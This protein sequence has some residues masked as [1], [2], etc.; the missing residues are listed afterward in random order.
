MRS[1]GG[2]S[3][4]GVGDFSVG[5]F[6]RDMVPSGG[7][8]GRRILSRGGISDVG[9]PASGGSDERGGFSQCAGVGSV[10]GLTTCGG[11]LEANGQSRSGCLDT[12]FMNRLQCA[13][14]CETCMGDPW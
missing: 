11:L 13:H 10:G 3:S 5:M 2:V 9:T 4:K 1:A 8:E 14:M 7:T 12:N 6:V